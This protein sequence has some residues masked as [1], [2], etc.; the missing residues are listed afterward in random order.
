MMPPGRWTADDLEKRALLE[1]GVAAAVNMEMKRAGRGRE[2][3]V[4]R[5]VAQTEPNPLVLRLQPD[6]SHSHALTEAHHIRHPRDPAWGELGDVDQAVAD[7]MLVRS[8]TDLH[9]GAIAGK[10]CHGAVDHVAHPEPPEEIAPPLPV[11]ASHGR[12]STTR[13]RLC[14]SHAR[15]SWS[16]RTTIAGCWKRRTTTRNAGRIGTA[17]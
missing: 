9:E 10:P 2:R 17:G 14:A 6:H 13:T 15:R 5:N 8:V 11:R 3:S 16:T 7:E 12:D 4:G 1:Q